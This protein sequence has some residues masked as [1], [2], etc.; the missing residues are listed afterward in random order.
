LSNL[1]SEKR[2]FENVAK[3]KLPEKT[4]SKA[5]LSANEISAAFDKADRAF[6]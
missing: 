2:L 1:H 3:A 6:Q 5:Q 4:F